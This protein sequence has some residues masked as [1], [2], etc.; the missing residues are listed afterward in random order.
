M[1]KKKWIALLMGLAILVMIALIGIRFFRK[2]QED[3]II[4][5]LMPATFSEDAGS[6][7]D[8]FPAEVKK[9]AIEDTKTVYELEDA[10]KVAEQIGKD[11]NEQQLVEL[12]NGRLFR[13][14]V[15]II[16]GQG[17]VFG[18]G[19]QQLSPR[20]LQMAGRDGI[21]IV[22]TRTKLIGLGGRPMTV[23]T[24]DPETD[25]MLSGYYRVVTGY[26]DYIPY[27]IVL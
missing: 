1:R 22:A 23:D 21:T 26:Q 11:L 6:I 19:N 15:T 5:K 9:R 13:I 14:I 16:G 2:P 25:Q 18:R 7:L 17:H 27:K 10:S 4:E 8:L 24:G 12:L 20:I 3:N